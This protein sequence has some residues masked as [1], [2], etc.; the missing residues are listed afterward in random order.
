MLYSILFVD[1]FLNTISESITHHSVKEEDCSCG[2]VAI[3]ESRSQKS[4]TQ[5]QIATSQQNFV[6]KKSNTL[7]SL[8][9]LQ[10]DDSLFFKN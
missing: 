2:I 1:S 6:S 3:L 10:V 5:S 4:F 7:V 9:I 8:G